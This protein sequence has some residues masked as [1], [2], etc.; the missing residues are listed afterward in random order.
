MIKVIIIENDLDAQDVLAMLIE[1][2]LPQ[3]QIMGNAANVVDGVK[4]I[5]KE[6]PNLVFLDIELNDGTGFDILNRLNEINFEIIFTSGYTEKAIDAFKYKAVHFLE[7]PVNPKDLIEAVS[8][9]KINDENTVQQSDDISEL[10]NKLNFR[11]RIAVP[12]TDGIKYIPIEDIVLVKGEGSYS[13]IQL[14]NGKSLLISKLIKDFESQLLE[15]RFYRASKSYLI[16][17]EQV[18]MYKRTDGGTIIMSDD[19]RIVLSRRKK[20]DFLIQLSDSI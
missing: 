16:N 7:K 20:D 6:C 3:L 10:V 11:K 9:V 2:Y 1:D 15:N 4:L 13:K 5:E 12:I 17:L 14:V 8:R 18:S 19:T